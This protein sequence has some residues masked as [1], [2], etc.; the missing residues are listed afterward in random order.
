DHFDG[1]LKTTL[2]PQ[3]FSKRI[4]IHT[5]QNISGFAAHVQEVWQKLFKN[6]KFYGPMK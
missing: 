5:I 2:S 6:D 4:S 1:I 3:G